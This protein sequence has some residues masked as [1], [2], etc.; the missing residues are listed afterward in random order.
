MFATTSNPLERVIDTDH[1]GETYA[2]TKT[3]EQAEFDFWQT[4]FGCG[5]HDPIVTDQAHLK[6]TAKR[7]AI[8]SSNGRH[9]QVFKRTEYGVDRTQPI[10]NRSFTLG[11]VVAELGN[12][13]TNDEYGL[14]RGDDHTCD[15]AVGFD[16]VGSGFKIFDGGAI[17]FINRF[18]L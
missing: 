2:T 17:E 15:V 6:A 18:A 7:D 3:R 1:A 13:G 14:A 12:V 9:R 8:N 10:S 16:R 11:E 4:D 5:G